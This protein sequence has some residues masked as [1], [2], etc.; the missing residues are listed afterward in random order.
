ML[1]LLE[2]THNNIIATRTDSMLSAAGYAKILP[3]VHN[4]ES[5]G[6]KVRWYFEIDD[7]SVTD[8]SFPIKAVRGD[9]CQVAFPRVATVE[10]IAIVA[11]EKWQVFLSLIKK[12]APN[13][14][15]RCFGLQDRKKAMKW[16]EEEK[17]ILNEK[18]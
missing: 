14:D 8:E 4:I 2:F 11:S 9:D 17:I 6:K 13:A 12:L 16:I 15:I 18:P 10:K 3:L 7:N 5:N 1:Q